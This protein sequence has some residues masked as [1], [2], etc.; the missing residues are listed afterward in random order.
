MSNYLQFKMN[1]NNCNSKNKIN[2]I[3]NMTGMNDPAFQSNNTLKKYIYK[4]LDSY[5]E[6]K[7]NILTKT[8]SYSKINDKSRLKII[9][10]IKNIY[11]NQ[12]FSKHSKL[13]LDNICN[14]EQEFK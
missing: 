14:F 3:K 7:S 9:Y 12:H 4:K 5:L 10:N 6:S 1:K 13:F 2:M 11:K 8:Q